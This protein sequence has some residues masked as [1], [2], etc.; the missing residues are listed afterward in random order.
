MKRPTHHPEAQLAARLG[1]VPKCARPV[2]CGLAPRWIFAIGGTTPPG[3]C[4]DS[5]SIWRSRAR[6][7]AAATALTLCCSASLAAADG[8]DHFSV[9][10]VAADDVLN[11]RAEPSP[12]A[13]RL[14]AMPAGADCIRNLGCQGGLSLQEF[15][16]LSKA[17]QQQ[18]LRENPRWCRI[19][20]RGITGWVAGRYLAE[21]SCPR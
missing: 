14:G 21:G 4:K 17:Q 9:R 15:T 2:S 7:A 11:I 18:R 3:R 16:T 20:W 6:H 8:P 13:A 1:A 10:D 5:A 12:K 19:E